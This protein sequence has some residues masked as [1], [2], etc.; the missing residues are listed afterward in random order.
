MKK[1]AFL[2]IILALGLLMNS[3]KP[4][5]AIGTVIINMDK[6]PDFAQR[7]EIK[8]CL[9]G[10]KGILTRP[11]DVTLYTDENHIPQYRA[12]KAKLESWGADVILRM[13]TAQNV[14]DFR[15]LGELAIY[16]YEGENI[17][18][19]FLSENAVFHSTGFADEEYDKAVKSGDIQRAHAILSDNNL[20]VEA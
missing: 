2:I 4:D 15:A 18:E 13:E 8:K 11:L 20:L 10:E 3:I 19:S 17:Y 1:L 7:L 16:I 9:E 6:I 14:F 5:E 12:L